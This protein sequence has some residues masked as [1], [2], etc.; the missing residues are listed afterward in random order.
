MKRFCWLL[1]AL[2]VPLCSVAQDINQLISAYQRGE[3]TPEQI[4]SLKR[5][6]GLS[7]PSKPAVVQRSRTIQPTTPPRADSVSLVQNVAIVETRPP[8]S[9]IF[10][11]DMF[12]RSAVGFEP[13]INIATPKGYLLGAGDIVVVDVWGDASHSAEYTIS[14]EGFIFVEGVGQ[15]PLAGITIEQAQ[16]RLKHRLQSIYAGLADGSVQ[17]SLSLSGVRSI[18]VYVVGEVVHQGSYSVPSLATLFHLLHLA[19][20]VSDRGGLREITIARRGEQPRKVDLYDYIIGGNH[21]VDVS[22][23]DGDLVLVSPP[24]MVVS[25]AG[26]VK[27]AMSYEMLPSESLSKIVEYAGGFAANANREALSVVR[28][29]GAEREHFVLSEA[30]ARDFLLCDGDSV[31]VAGGIDRDRNRVAVSGAVRRAGSYALDDDVRTLHDLLLRADGLRDDAFMERALLYREGDDWM[32]EMVAVNLNDVRQDRADVML[33]PNDSLVV[34][35]VGQMVEPLTVRLF[36]SVQHEGTYPYVENMTLKDL[37]VEA[38]GLL[39]EASHAKITISRRIRKPDSLAPQEILFENFSLSLADGLSADDAEFRL[40]P[41]DEVYVRRSPVYITQSSV[42]VQG[43]VAFEGSYPLVRRNM[44]LSDVV[45]EAGGLTSGAFAEGAYLLRRMT[46]EEQRQYQT[47]QDMIHRQAGTVEHDSVLL[48]ASK[49]YPVGINLAE[50]ISSP[51]SDADVVLRDG[52]MVAVPKYNA[53]VRVMGAVLYPNSVTFREGETMKYYIRSA[54]GFDGRARR[55]HSF[56]IYMNGMVASG[57]DAAIR[58]GC[59]IIVPSK[60]IAEPLKL[61][62]V[63]GLMST[64]A[65]MAAIVVSLI[66]IA[67]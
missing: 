49:V 19:G 24:R 6:Y 65:S 5:E 60:S 44:R 55:R 54:G 32:G 57:R 59:I 28:R 41:F 45:R 66:N 34:R 47:L 7:T 63:M 46:D 22:L 48:A 18:V 10:G 21:S 30:A 52:D 2:F 8:K 62:D 35:S 25:V 56:V 31:I 29:Q 3:I 9:N 64:T 38:G 20:G 11:H 26:E 39:Q 1:V 36:G 4:E 50:A 14:P 42:S 43:E 16:R 51:G 27:R 67:N 33:R 13:Q 15:I 53:T 17:L 23:R 40:Q 58:P 12:S 37:L 61:G